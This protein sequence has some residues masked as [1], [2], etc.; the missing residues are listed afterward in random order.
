MAEINNILF[1]LLTFTVG[2]YFLFMIKYRQLKTIYASYFV[3]LLVIFYGPLLYYKLGYN[4]YKWVLSSK[5]INIFQIIGIVVFFL[6]IIF[7]IV[8][9]GRKNY[10]L[11]KF[12]TQIKTRE[13]RNKN[14]LTLYFLLVFFFVILYLLIYFKHFPVISL[15][16]TGKLS[17]RLDI[18]GSIPLYITV[19]SVFM[20]ILPS[21]FLYL[22]YRNIS[23]WLKI[24][25]FLITL[26][27]LI[28]G[29]NKGIISFFLLF[30]VYYSARKNRILKFAF[31][32]IFLIFIYALTKGITEI[33]KETIAYLLEA[34]FRRMFATQGVGFIARIQLML[35]NA[36]DYE[37]T[38]LIKQQVYSL[39]YS[40]PLGSGSHPTYFL[41]NLIVQ[42]GYIIAFFFYLLY[43][44]IIIN[45]IKTVDHLFSGKKDL[46]IIW[47]IFVIIYLFSMSDISLANL[48]R[49]SFSVINILMINILLR[50]KFNDAVFYKE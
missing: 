39:I 8:K 43:L 9:T 32:F 36:I 38:F 15:F 16:L 19:S 25:L 14:I 20:T 11:L 42:Y 12:F 28:S 37:S 50:V 49:I 26:L 30:F 10:L 34:P 13:N 3:M 31:L 18:T 21:A 17:A 24:I 33:N 23:T 22:N 41:G 4:G 5:A 29:G 45:L 48:I 46:Y 2:L 35:D 1:F 27:A 40:E 6:N 44:V 7:L 47:N